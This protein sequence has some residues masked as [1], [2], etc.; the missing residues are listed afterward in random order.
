[1]L[2]FYVRHGDPIYD[3][4]SL[5]ELGHQ[6]AKVLADRMA[7]CD[8]GRIFASPSNRAMQTAQ[9]TA[10]RLGKEIEVLDWCHEDLA[11]K[12][13]GIINDEGKWQWCFANKKFK[14]MFVS[15][16]VRKLDRQWYDHPDFAGTGFRAGVERVQKET[17]AFLASLGYR[18]VPEQGGYIAE[19]PND[20]RIAL[21]AHQG[22]G[23]IFLSCL[24]DIPY[25]QFC[26]HFDLGHSTVTVIE[27]RGEGLV[28]PKMLQ[29][30]ND[31]HI[32][33]A[34]MDTVYNRYIRF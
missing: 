34:G 5:T 19:R 24:M 29:L 18:H 13:F 11:G 15:D 33:S 17:D 7:V 2:F 30:S 25:P 14:K 9:P 21:F 1:M 3:P 26:T 16:A 28:I 10:Q 32:F 12:D 20:D 6:Q 27:F 22:F 31:S 23:L 4:D 8:P